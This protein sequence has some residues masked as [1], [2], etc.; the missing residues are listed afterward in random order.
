MTADNHHHHPEVGGDEGFHHDEHHD[1]DHHVPLWILALV[2]SFV[3]VL[4]V[5]P[6]IL[7]AKNKRVEKQD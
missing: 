4:I 6:N 7:A 5:L 2:G 3:A 1:D